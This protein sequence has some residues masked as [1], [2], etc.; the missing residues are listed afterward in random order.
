MGKGGSNTL[1][2]T[3][4]DGKKVGVIQSFDKHR[5]EKVGVIHSFD[6][7]RWEKVGSNTLV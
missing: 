5:W 2:W 4:T 6:K 7:H 1:I 3:N